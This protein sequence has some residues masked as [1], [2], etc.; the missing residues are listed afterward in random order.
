M[1]SFDFYQIE[2]LQHKGEWEELTKLMVQEAHNLKKASAECIV[3]CTNTM[4]LMAPDIEKDTGLKV[5]HIADATGN[6]IIK[7][8]IDKVLL[9][10]TKFTMEGSFYKERLNRKGIEVLI[11]DETDRQIIHDIIYKELVVGILSPESK[12][13]YIEIINKAI[14]K[15]ITGVVLGCTEIPLLI[16][17]TDVTIEVFDTTKIHAKAAVEFA[18]N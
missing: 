14:E 5:I 10:G 18:I 8:N 17:Q 12:R 3:I 13:I 9:L 4:H 2:K 1:Y 11:P 16:K 15:G 7:R 6:E